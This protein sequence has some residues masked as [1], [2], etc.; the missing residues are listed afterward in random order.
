M[1]M[2]PDVRIPSVK[3]GPRNLCMF[4]VNRKGTASFDAKTGACPETPGS[5][6]LIAILPVERDR[7]N[8]DGD[9]LVRQKTYV[10]KLVA[11]ICSANCLRIFQRSAGPPMTLSI[12]LEELSQN[13]T[14]LGFNTQQTL[15][16]TSSGTSFATTSSMMSFRKVKYS[17]LPG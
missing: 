2:M 16:S 7:W 9:L 13:L 5:S 17:A 3:R 1:T 4:G 15:V 10:M 11:A 12:Y 8:R 6:S 14:K